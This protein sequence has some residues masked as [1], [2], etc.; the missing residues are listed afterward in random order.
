MLVNDH[1]AESSARLRKRLRIRI[2]I[3][4][5]V[6]LGCIFVMDAVLKGI[7]TI[8]RL[9]QVESERD[10]WQKAPEVI[11]AMKLE[12]GNVVADFGSGA[13]YFA[14]KLSRTVGARG[15][16]F[17]VDIR[18]LPLT[19]LWI[20]A[21][22]SGQ[23]NISVHLE[24][25]NDPHLPPGRLDGVLI[26]N[27]YHELSNS[28]SILTHII[29][30]LKP[31]GRLVILDRSR[32]AGSQGGEPDDHHQIEPGARADGDKWWLVVVIKKGR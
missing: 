4:L 11:A 32:T 20:R 13:G 26:A 23:H 9:E 27:T 19:F 30:S 15:R 25:A 2:A 18:R 6:V 1:V 17:A 8:N 22:L 5:L 16:V 7:N 10:H 29:N 28:A 24:D 14:L 12:R 21:F 3:F 31:S